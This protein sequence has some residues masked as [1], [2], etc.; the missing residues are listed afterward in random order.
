MAGMVNEQLTMERIETELLIVKG[1]LPVYELMGSEVVEALVV[2][3]LESNKLTS[4]MEL[5]RK[6][7][8]FTE[9]KAM[10]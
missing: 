9:K 6:R 10:G 3:K 4:P 5:E 1:V 2:E 8:V 7:S